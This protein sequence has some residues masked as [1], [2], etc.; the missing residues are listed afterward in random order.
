MHKVTHIDSEITHILWDS[1]GTKLLLADSNSQILLWQMHESL[2]NHWTLSYLSK[3]LSGDDVIA[4]KWINSSQMVNLLN[5]YIDIFGVE[6][7]TLG[8]LNVSLYSL[9]IGNFV[10]YPCLLDMISVVFSSQ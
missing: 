4:L 6:S 10:T 7:L 3:S 1:S 8:R 5:S 9:A 2:I